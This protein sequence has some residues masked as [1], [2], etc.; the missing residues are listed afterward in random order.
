MG[1]APRFN[2]YLLLRA[3]VLVVVRNIHQS[4]TRSRPIWQ[5]H[6]V[7]SFNGQHVHSLWQ[8][9]IRATYIRAKHCTPSRVGL[10]L[11]TA[12]AKLQSLTAVWPF[13]TLNRPTVHVVHSRLVRACSRYI[14]NGNPAFGYSLMDDGCFDNLSHTHEM[15]HNLGC[16]HDRENSNTITDYSHGWRYCTGDAQ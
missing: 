16:Y 1:A 13:T 7:V 10:P 2:V 3:S 12:P 9:I 8:A 15:G 4:A 11:S 5:V 6:N 14:F